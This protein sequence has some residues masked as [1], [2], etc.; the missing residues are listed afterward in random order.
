[1]NDLNTRTLEET[2]HERAGSM[3]LP[4]TA[5]VELIDRA[6]RQRRRRAALGTMGGVAATAAAALVAVLVMP[7]PAPQRPVGP[8][9][10]QA[11]TTSASEA[12]VRQ[13]PLSIDDIA[14]VNG[15]H[16]WATALP[17]GP[18]V[19]RDLG[20]AAWRENGRI[21]LRIGGRQV[22]MGADVQL[23]SHPAKVPDGWL[24][25]AHD[26]SSLPATRVLHVDQDLNVTVVAE[27]EDI[28]QVVAAPGGGGF[29]VVT[30]SVSK[31]E[32][33]PGTVTFFSS[34][35]GQGR[36]LELPGWHEP[37]IATWDGDVVT[38]PTQGGHPTPLRS[39]DLRTGRWSDIPLAPSLADVM[40]I[41]VLALPGARGGDP[42]R[43][44]VAVARSSGA[45]CAHLLEGAE[46][47]PEAILCGASASSW[48]WATV[49]PDGARAVIGD[50]SYER[51]NVDR[52]TR[53]INLG[54]M[55]DV[56]GV[57]QEVLAVGV[58]H[59]YWENEHALIGGANR[60]T[61]VHRSETLFRWDLTT[62]V[63][64]ALEWRAEDSPIPRYAG[65]EPAVW[66]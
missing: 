3:P 40:D 25:A 55:T 45:T 4:V 23:L 1:M 12:P 32:V 31:E 38:F 66:P 57:P 17:P 21:V 56:P 28:R 26:L 30:V 59:L 64:E 5:G 42:A 47:V 53:V 49:S 37:L 58:G 51:F 9:A 48:L 27:G 54:T 24:F 36:R 19:R 50:R 65:D 2:L 60:V 14:R 10:S 34:D 16:A 7:S 62:S 6:G 33:L 52:P 35:G 18:A 46:I 41:R 44:I 20:Y 15:V 29:A 43:A 61:P 22:V 63:G 39:Y 8:A 13:Q 11:P